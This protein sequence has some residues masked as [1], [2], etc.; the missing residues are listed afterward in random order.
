[1]DS[2]GI[3]HNIQKGVFAIKFTL[4]ITQQCNLACTY[5]Y[6]SKQ[7]ASMD[8]GTAEKIIDFVFDHARKGEKNHVGLFGGEPLLEFDLM[9]QIVEAFEQHPRFNEF[10]MDFSVVSNGTLFSDEIADFLLAH[11]AIYCVSCDGDSLAQDTFRRFRGGGSTSHIVGETLRQA[12]ARLPLVLVNAVYAPETLHLLPDTVR[13]FMDLGLRQIYLS[14]DLSASW[15]PEHIPVLDTALAQIADI[16]IDAYRKSRPVYI[17]TLDDKIAV[18]LR[19]GYKPEERCHM[20]VREFAFTPNGD[21]FPCERIVYDGDPSSAHCLGHVDTGV[22]LSRLSC[23]MRAEGD[24]DNPC[25]TCSMRQYC[26]NWCGCSNFHA[27]GYYNSAGAYQCAEEKSS[28]RT[29]LQVIK[30]LEDEFPTVFATHA[31]GFTS[32]N[33]WQYP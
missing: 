21:I 18:I 20:G 27:T 10:E 32:L 14:A 26:I 7:P 16:Y 3:Y 4:L 9:R 25:L 23:H 28:L 31:A 6:I 5:C 19:G 13:Y 17:S 2:S 11:D 22:D 24:G 8:M 29:A 1:M 15:K 30:T 33:I 12:V